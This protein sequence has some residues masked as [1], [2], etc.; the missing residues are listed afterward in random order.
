[1]RMVGL[2]VEDM[3]NSDPTGTLN[4]VVNL[5]LQKSSYGSSPVILGESQQDDNVTGTFLPARLKDLLL[6]LWTTLSGS[7][8]S[9]TGLPR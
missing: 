8:W 5:T 7:G 2:H 9:C 3:R 4:K 1:M 6:P